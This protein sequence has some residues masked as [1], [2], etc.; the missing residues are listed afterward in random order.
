[1]FS[2]STS[3]LIKIVSPVVTVLLD[4]LSGDRPMA[5]TPGATI[6]SDRSGTD[7]DPALSWKARPV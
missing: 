4:T 3:A 5:P 2:P 7:S 6:V 1:M